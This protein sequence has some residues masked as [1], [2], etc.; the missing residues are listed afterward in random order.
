MQ[1]LVGLMLGRASDLSDEQKPPD[2]VRDVMTQAASIAVMGG[3]TLRRRRG[4]FG[5]SSVV[6][7]TC[8]G[9]TPRRGA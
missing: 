7:P 4:A 6:P 1:F 3:I 5:R 2:S 8:S 9:G